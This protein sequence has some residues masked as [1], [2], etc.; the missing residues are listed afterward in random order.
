MPNSPVVIARCQ[1]KVVCRADWDAM[2][3]TNRPNVKVCSE[4][5]RFVHL[6]ETG[7]QLREAISL[8][9]CI[10]AADRDASASDGTRLVLGQID[11]FPTLRNRRPQRAPLRINQREE[12]IRNSGN[13]LF[14][15]LDETLRKRFCTQ[16]R[17]TTCGAMDFRQELRV[18]V[19]GAIGRAPQS[20][21]GDKDAALAI[22]GELS[23]IEISKQDP[24][25]KDFEPAVRLII[26]DIWDIVPMAVE[27]ITQRVAGSYGQHVLSLMQAHHA[28]G[29]RRAAE[30]E[31]SQLEA[32]E[33]R[34]EK[35]RLRRERH[36]ARLVL[37]DERDRNRTRSTT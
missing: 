21:D 37:K 16:I 27:E 34:I 9:Q 18:R 33:K 19:G 24:R 8:G 6:C 5:D 23:K 35:V 20:L 25:F 1:F 15:F 12:L 22:L 13:W 3:S 10:A 31:R 2:A 17:C 11:E 29:I 30:H 36:V 14:D 26:F 32:Q 28:A 7:E 4:C